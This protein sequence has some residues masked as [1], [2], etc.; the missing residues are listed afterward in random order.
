MKHNTYK[1]EN[2]A[3]PLP[4]NSFTDSLSYTSVSVTLWSSFYSS[5]EESWKTI[6]LLV[7]VKLLNLWASVSSLEKK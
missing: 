4:F 1:N 2:L 7:M 5:S 3:S 6:P